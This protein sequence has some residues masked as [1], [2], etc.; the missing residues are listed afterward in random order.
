MNA[1]Y[2]VLLLRVVFEKYTSLV[3]CRNNIVI[4]TMV[5]RLEMIEKREK[6]TKRTN[7]GT[8]EAKRSM[9]ARMAKSHNMDG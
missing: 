2:F 3:D 7:P 5:N 9:I 8:E 1:R 6:G 4:D